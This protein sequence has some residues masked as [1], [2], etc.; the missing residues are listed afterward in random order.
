V[1]LAV[2]RG[3]DNPKK[4]EEEEEEE[5]QWSHDQLNSQKK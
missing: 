1:L 3:A 2:K 4:E 5:E